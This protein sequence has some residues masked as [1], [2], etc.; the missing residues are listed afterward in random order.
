MIL[1][2]P[3]DGDVQMSKV[4]YRPRTCFIMTQLRSPIPARV[5]EIR[6][7]LKEILIG[8]KM[9]EIDASN[10]ITGKDFLL[11]IWHLMIAVPLG[12]AIID[13]TIRFNA[14][15]NIFYE[16][17][18]MHGLGKETVVVKAEKALVPS[19]FIRTEYIKYD[20]DFESNFKKYFETYWKLPDYYETLADQLDRNP[21]L[22]IDYLRRAY[23]ISG[24][25]KLR[26][27]AQRY[28]KEAALEERA[29]NSVEQLLVGF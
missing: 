13:E 21:L 27:K 9:N 22:A 4:E 7:K 6:E 25:N 11:K 17:G 1:Y 10:V 20:S 12:V 24:R 18:L 8:N 2:K 19:D 29:K 23:L 14:L 5:K 3:T 16:I 15:C 26:K 28:H